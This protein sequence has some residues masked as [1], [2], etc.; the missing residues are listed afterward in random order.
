MNNFKKQIYQLSEIFSHHRSSSKMFGLV[1]RMFNFSRMKSCGLSGQLMARAV[2]IACRNEKQIE[3][4]QYISRPVPYTLC[5]KS[6]L[7]PFYFHMSKAHEIPC[8]STDFLTKFQ[9]F[10]DLFPADGGTN[11]REFHEKF[12][13]FAHSQG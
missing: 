13:E 6:W 12:E 4:D 5:M 2:R 10:P 11:D 7:G 8:L 3:K 9:K 1:R